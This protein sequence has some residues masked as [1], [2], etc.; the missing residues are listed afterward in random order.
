MRLKLGMVGG[1]KGAFIG[2]M[3]RIA[4]RLDGHWDLVAGAFSSDPERAGQSATDLGVAAERSYDSWA[5]MAKADAARSDGID[6]VAI[7]TPNH[8]QA[9]VA[10]AFLRAGIPVICD[11]RRRRRGPCAAGVRNRPA[12]HPDP[13]LHRL[14]DGPRGAGAGR[15]GSHRAGT[16]C[17]G[18]VFAGPIGRTGGAHRAPAGRMAHRPGAVRPRRVH[19]RD[20]STI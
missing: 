9:P 15:G 5:A 17:A 4:A 10:T 18:G 20:R 7:V 12:L 6:A 3:H 11:N 19:R 1:G 2:G 8:L 16:P 13:D 14:S